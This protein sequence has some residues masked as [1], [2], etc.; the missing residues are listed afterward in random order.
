MK[1]ILL[2]LL[3]S[4]SVFYIHAQSLV[5][6]Y[7]N[8]DKEIKNDTS[9]IAD[10]AKIRLPSHGAQLH[11]DYSNLK[12]ILEY[13]EVLNPSNHP[14]FVNS[15]MFTPNLKTYLVYPI[16]YYEDKYYTIDTLGYYMNGHHIQALHHGLSKITG[17]S[18]DSLIIDAQDDVYT[19]PRY[20]V[21]FPAAYGD[22]V[23]SSHIESLKMRL[24]ISGEGL[25][26][27]PFERKKY[28]TQTDSIVGSGT[29]QLPTIYQSKSHPIAT[30]LY[31][32][33]TTVID[34][35]YINNQPASTALLSLIK[36]KQGSSYQNSQYTFWREN[37]K[38]PLISF[39]TTEDFKKIILINYDNRN[40][41]TLGIDL[42]AMVYTHANLFPNP[43]S[44]GIANLQLMKTQV[45]PWLL[46][47]YNSLGQLVTHDQVLGMGPI[48]KQ[49]H[50][51]ASSG[52]YIVKLLTADGL[53]IYSQKIVK[54]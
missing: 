38:N 49:L 26:N 25:L 31:K 4:Q 23:T 20:I 37:S 30:L 12:S 10:T 39:Y 54:Q 18:D 48:Q 52:V 40:L 9:Q 47:V 11:W 15:S 34:S 32:R 17:N 2:F 29:I 13:V 22:V 5:I 3:F 27:A 45:E 42:N 43:T 35:F 7:P 46:Q 1:P 36:F 33:T 16:A 44:D 14:A 28:I 24:S 50:L 41:Y 21:K 51:P 6:A 53:E 19:T 8:F